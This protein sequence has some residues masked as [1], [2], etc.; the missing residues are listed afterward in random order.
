M[1]HL[2]RGANSAN[3]ERR[4]QF[5][6]GRQAETETTRRIR[7]GYCTT[8]ARP[9]SLVIVDL[10][11]RALDGGALLLGGLAVD[12]GALDALG[13]QAL[14]DVDLDLVA[15][16]DG[17]VEEAARVAVVE[18]LDDGFAACAR[19]VVLVGAGGSAGRRG[20]VLLLSLVCRWGCIVDGGSGGGGLWL[21]QWWVVA[22][23]A[24][25]V[26]VGKW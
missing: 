13:A 5:R 4:S 16:A 3:I 8:S 2:R 10:L 1:T 21:R 7:P 12:A 6:V 20:V 22:L 18:R 23:L 14:C 25:L 24:C 26:G 17:L 15:H 11:P 19:G 9:R